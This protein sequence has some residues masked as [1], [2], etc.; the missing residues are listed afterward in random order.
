[1]RREKLM[2]GCPGQALSSV[3]VFSFFFH[4]VMLIFDTVSRDVNR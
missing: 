3:R 4:H 1:M 2:D